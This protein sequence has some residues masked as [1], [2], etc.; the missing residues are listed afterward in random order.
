MFFVPGLFDELA[1]GVIVFRL[2]DEN[3]KLVLFL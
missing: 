2:P 1:E 3:E